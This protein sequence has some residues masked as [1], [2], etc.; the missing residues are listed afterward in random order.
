MIKYISIL[1]LLLISTEIISAQDWLTKIDQPEELGNVKWLRS[2]DDAIEQSKELDK[3]L[4]ILFQ[5]VP[6]C[7][8]CKNYGNDLLRHPHIVEAIEMYFIPLAIFNNKKGADADILRK[9]NEPAWNNP[10][11]RIIDSEN[12]KDIVKRLNGKYDLQ[13]LV[14]FISNGMIKSGQL[15]PKY[16][17]ILYKEASVTD[18]RE[19]H[20]SMYCFWTGEKTLGGLDGVV[21]TK[22][23]YM[24]GT[25]VVKVH[26]DAKEISEEELITF[27]SSKQCADAVYTED[28]REVKAAKKHSIRTNGEGK[29]RA[30]KESKYYIYNTDYKY[31]PMTSLQALKVNTALSK[32][33]SPEAYLSPRQLVLLENVKNEKVKSK[34]SIDKDFVVSWEQYYN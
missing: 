11:A 34:A 16:L 33:Q 19:T 26:Y 5:E 25:E 7:S 31:L 28:Q 32:R 17:D 22:A 1:M 30:D 3:P 9:F 23:G 10:V 24:N 12:E 2:Y 20:L 29:F 21:A 8:T 27:A 15:I 4:F 6:G 18:L 13:S 14:S